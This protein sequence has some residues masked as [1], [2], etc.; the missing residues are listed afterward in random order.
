[1][2][3]SIARNCRIHVYIASQNEIL[4]AQ[5]VEDWPRI[6]GVIGWAFNQSYTISGR[7]NGNILSSMIILFFFLQVTDMREW[8]WGNMFFLMRTQRI[9]FF[10]LIPI[11]YFITILFFYIVKSSFI[12]SDWLGSECDVT[13]KKL[14]KC[15][16]YK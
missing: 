1:M 12:V 11:S 15:L 2:H 5:S 8:Y 13:M 10:F 4:I 14:Q 6:R 7:W 16:S 9:C 3:I